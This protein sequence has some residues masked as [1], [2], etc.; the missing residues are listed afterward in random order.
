MKKEQAIDKNYL[1]SC[2]LKEMEIKEVF[3]TSG[4]ALLESLGALLHDV[5]CSDHGYIL[6]FKQGDL[7]S[8]FPKI[9]Q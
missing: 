2:N 6:K 5:F 4:G 9:I 3:G 7:N 1:N 8:Q